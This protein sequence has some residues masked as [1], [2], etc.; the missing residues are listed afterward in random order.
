MCVQNSATILFAKSKTAHKPIAIG[1]KIRAI[2]MEFAFIK[3]AFIF[4]PSTICCSKSELALTVK[5]AV[6]KITDVTVAFCAAVLSVTMRFGFVVF[7]SVSVTIGPSVLALAFS[8]VVPP[9]TNV[10]AIEILIEY[11]VHQLNYLCLIV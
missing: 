8:Q 11:E 1:V 4:I 9:I 3:I 6:C 5:I 10:P 7:S 2:P